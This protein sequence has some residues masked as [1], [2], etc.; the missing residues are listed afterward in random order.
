MHL[1]IKKLG[2]MP[3]FCNEEYLIN[4]FETLFFPRMGIENMDSSLLRMGN[5]QVLNL[6]YNKL[7]SLPTKLLPPKLQELN[8]TGNMITYVTTG[9]H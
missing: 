2:M 4:F 9:S 3:D 6:S 5:L 8:L 1:Y 7:T